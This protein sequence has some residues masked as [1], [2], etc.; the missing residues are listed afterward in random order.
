MVV[1]KQ[2]LIGIS[3]VE[4]MTGQERSTIRRKYRADK[5]PKPRYYGTRRMW[6]VSEIE[7]WI[8]S[9]EAKP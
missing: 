7:Q 2:Q 4:T 1:P 3:G 5:F 8:A 9:G 6:L